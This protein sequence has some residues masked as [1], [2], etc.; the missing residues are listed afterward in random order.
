MW[1]GI[2]YGRVIAGTGRFLGGAEPEPWEGIRP[3]LRYGS[4]S[5]QLPAVYDRTSGSL[6]DFEF[7]RNGDQEDED[8]LYLNVYTP[9]PTRAGLP[10]IVWFHPGMQVAGSGNMPG[11]RPE[12]LSWNHGVV[13]VTMNYRLGC[14]GHLFLDE[15]DAAGAGTADSA[16]LRMRDQILALQWVKA[17]IEVFGGDSA[18]VTLVGDSSG[19]RN[20]ATLLGCPLADGLFE[21]AALYSGAGEDALPRD[22]ATELT[23]QFLRCADLD[24]APER[25]H[26]VPNMHF[27][28]AH[29]RLLRQRELVNYRDVVDGR[30]L[31]HLPV[32]AVQN[33]VCRGVELLV[34]NTEDEAGLWNRLMP[35]GARVVARAACADSPEKEKRF[36]ARYRAD[37]EGFINQEL[38]RRPARD[39]LQAKCAAGGARCWYQI[40]DYVPSNHT[41]AGAKHAVHGMDLASLLLDL[42]SPGDVSGTDIAVARNIQSALVDFANGRAPSSGGVAWPV[43]ERE[44]EMMVRVGAEVRA[45]NADAALP[46]G[47]AWD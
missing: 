40:Y 30:Y 3:A 34:S 27:K 11:R 24:S 19:A 13:V 1:R 44:T 28:V 39:L 4:V 35:N 5:W 47:A 10:V 37:Y 33:G 46:G 8:C 20:I 26:S 23:H 36:L 17:N 15:L 6:R 7:T 16:N 22:W 38:F 9:D 2:P 18:R 42:A 29:G 14:W 41:F 25:I 21:R 12:V 43:Y 31:S 32:E 45:E